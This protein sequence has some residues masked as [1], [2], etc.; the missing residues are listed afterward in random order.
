LEEAIERSLDA[1]QASVVRAALRGETP[2]EIAGRS[3]LAAKMISNEKALAIRE[4][5]LALAGASDP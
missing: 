1:R 2:A 4:L 3:G 5:R